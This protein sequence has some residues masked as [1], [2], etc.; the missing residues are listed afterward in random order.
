MRAFRWASERIG[1]SGIVAFVTNN[2]FIEDWT[3]D[4]MRKHLAEEFNALYLLNLGGNIR[5]GQ[6]ADSN[7]FSP[8]STV[9]VSIAMLVRN[10]R[11][12]LILLVSF[13]ND[14]AENG[15]KVQKFHFS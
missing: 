4:G 7:V 3:F 14:E 11:N 10:G 8:K 6:S 13:Y 9:G 1:D 12:L 5:K 15:S 2:S